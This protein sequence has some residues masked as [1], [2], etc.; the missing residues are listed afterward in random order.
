MA[1]DE[2]VAGSSRVTVFAVFGVVLGYATHHLDQRRLGEV[3]IVGPLT[4]GVEWGRLWQMARTCERTTAGEKELAQWVLTQ[5][6]RAFVCGSDRVAQFQ[7]RRWRLEPGGRRVRFDA[8]YANRDQLWTGNLTVE[9][10]TP[11]QT[12]ERPT[13]YAV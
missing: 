13:L 8:T 7:E 4:P 2:G 10:L 5:A 12:A 6:T 1:S 11:D 9:G 3:A